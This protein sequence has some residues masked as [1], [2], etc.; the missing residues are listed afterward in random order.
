MGVWRWM[1]RVIL[2]VATLYIFL[3]FYMLY[4]NNHI[5]VC[6]FVCFENF[7]VR[8]RNGFDLGALRVLGGVKRFAM[9][10]QVRLRVQEACTY[11]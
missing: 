8:V 5:G 9:G 3:C 10:T 2:H 11:I 1:D 4:V 6:P 7:Y